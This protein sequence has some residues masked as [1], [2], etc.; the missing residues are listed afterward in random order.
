LDHCDD[1]KK[2]QI[3]SY[4][5]MSSADLDAAIKEKEAELQAA[6]NKFKEEIEKLQGKYEQLLEFK[7]ATH[8]FMKRSGLGLMKA[9]QASA[10]KVVNATTGKANDEL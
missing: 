2:A 5:E 9:V 3:K 6:E 1:E 8:D 7:E 10:R 4:K